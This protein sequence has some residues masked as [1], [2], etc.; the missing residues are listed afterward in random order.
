MKGESEPKLKLHQHIQGPTKAGPWRCTRAFASAPERT[1]QCPG[2]V[3]TGAYCGWWLRIIL[4]KDTQYII[5]NFKFWLF[6]YIYIFTYI[7]IIYVKNIYIYTYIN[8]IYIY[9]Y[10]NYIYIFIYI[11][12]YI[13]IICI[14]NLFIYIC[15][16][17]I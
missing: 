6:I 2:S 5:Y 3:I 4:P 11:N 7:Y 17:Y 14:N 16:I 13:Y 15:N 10:I 9:T 8:Y 12:I 1:W